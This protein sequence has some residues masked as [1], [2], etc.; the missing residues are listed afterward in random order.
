MRQRGW[1]LKQDEL[2]EWDHIP[3]W[4]RVQAGRGRAKIWHQYV[5]TVI[6]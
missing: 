3:Q 5:K 2:C 4:R 1:I 6:T